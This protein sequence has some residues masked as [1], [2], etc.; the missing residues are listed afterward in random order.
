MCLVAL[1]F[2]VVVTTRADFLR[3]ED[4]DALASKPADHRIAYG[5]QRLQYGELRLPK[6]EGPHPVAIVIHGGCWI[7]RFADLRNTAALSDAL[8]DEGVATWNI[9]YR[10]IGNQGGGWPGTFHDI[11]RAVD[12]LRTIATNYQLDLERVIVMGHSAGGHLALWSAGRHRLPATGRLSDKDPLPLSGVVALAGIGNLD[13]YAHSGIGICARAA[14]ALVGGSRSQNPERYAQASP[15]ELLPLGVPQ[16]LIT[17]SED[18][19]V[20]VHLGADYAQAALRAGD[21]VKHIIVDNAGHHEY[22]APTSVTWTAI[23]QSVLSLL[24]MEL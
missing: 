9:E 20:P 10:R 21:D 14:M 7:A 17:G 22:N 11:A 5:S 13:A 3:P 2:G 1:L 4:V 19:I 24:K 8:R 18:G 16:I 15:I 6:S 23:R 12:H